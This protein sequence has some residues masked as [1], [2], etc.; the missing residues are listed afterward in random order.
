[1]MDELRRKHA[2]RQSARSSEST[3]KAC[4][5]HET[6]SR[7]LQRAAAPKGADL[8]VASKDFLAAA[9]RSKFATLNNSQQELSPSS[10]RVNASIWDED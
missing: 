8:A 1:M 5:L 4:D 3:S 9:L 10:S 6:I 2:S 7:S